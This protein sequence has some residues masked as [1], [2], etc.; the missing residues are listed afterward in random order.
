MVLD[1]W[2]LPQTDRSGWIVGTEIDTT[3]HLWFL[4]AFLELVKFWKRTLM[5]MKK[6]FF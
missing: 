5:L 3:L 4:H 2:V 6:M 1:D